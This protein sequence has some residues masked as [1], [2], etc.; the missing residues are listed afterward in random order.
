MSL[1]RSTLAPCAA[2]LACVAA[3]SP[4]PSR[5]PPVP[6][7][8]PV[9]R[10]SAAPDPVGFG[11]DLPTVAGRHRTLL[12]VAGL[13]REV[14]LVIPERRPPR[15]ALLLILHG[16]GGDGPGVTDECGALGL[17]T[18]EGVI[19][20]APTART[21]DGTDWDHPA[22]SGETWWETQRVDPASNPDILL[23][24]ATLAA[25]LRDLHV[26]PARVYLMGHANGAF[27]GLVVAMT[28]RQ[29]FAGVALNAGGLVRCPASASCRF[30]GGTVADC[31]AYP[32]LPGWCAG[33]AGP[34][35]PLGVSPA[36]PRVPF[37]LSHG[38][39]DP[40]VSVQHTCALAAE[41]RRADFPVS[42]QLRPGDGHL[43]DSDFVERSWR[44][45]ARLAAPR[46]AGE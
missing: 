12:R 6:A 22:A 23:V 32:A 41:L 46:A 10:A 31:A 13:D 37:V 25:A 19:V 2:L 24:R 44:E 34:P 11:G 21:M 28:L 35:L 42:V 38:T 45:L 1:P 14:A 40:D 3:P 36:A 26:D 39:D 17:A 15:P 7:T 5:P 8:A 20:A 29:P 18:H 33:C 30:R 27:L 16:T 9:F 43:C 4:V